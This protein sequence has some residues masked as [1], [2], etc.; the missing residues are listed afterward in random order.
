MADRKGRLLIFKTP[1]TVLLKDIKDAIT[2]EVGPEKI[3]VIQHLNTG[4]YLVELIENKLAEDL[5]ENC[6]DLEELHV[7]CNPPPPPVTTMET[8]VL[9]AFVPTWK[10][11]H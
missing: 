5:I 9:W 2:A 8:S 1:V 6:F 10:T 4:E 3:T 7:Q 11:K